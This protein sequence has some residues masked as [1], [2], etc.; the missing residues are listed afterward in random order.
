MN[1]SVNRSHPII[2]KPPPEI[3]T[4]SNSFVTYSHNPTDETENKFNFKLSNKYDGI[5]AVALHSFTLPG[6]DHINNISSYFNNNVLTFQISVIYVPTDNVDTTDV[7]TIAYNVLTSNPLITFSCTFEDAYYDNNDFYQYLENALNNSVSQFIETYLEE[8]GSSDLETFSLSTGYTDF[9]VKYLE[10]EN[11]YIIANLRSQFILT[12]LHTLITYFKCGNNKN[13]P[14][15]LGFN[16]ENIE[17]TIL[18]QSQNNKLFTETTDT[19]IYAVKS[20]NVSRINR[21]DVIFLFIDQINFIDFSNEE[22]QLYK[23]YFHQLYLE[24]K[25]VSNHVKI[26][27]SE[28]VFS[29]V[30]YQNSSMDKFSFHFRD[31]FDRKLDFGNVQF[32]ITL[33]LRTI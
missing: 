25:D 11:K 13:L 1:Y 20:S 32:D 31:L 14:F 24:Q 15:M 6:T 10:K 29:L 18:K 26:D 7:D 21:I 2:E 8:T 27:N 9:K 28:R 23:H 30:S 4:T 22:K 19:Q 33:T 3:K 17:S 16:D 5:T 12:N